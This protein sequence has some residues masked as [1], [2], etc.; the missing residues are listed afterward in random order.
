MLVMVGV[1]NAKN[2]TE[3]LGI[4][5]PAFERLGYESMFTADSESAVLPNVK[6]AIA[7]VLS[8][9]IGNGRSVDDIGNDYKNLQMYKGDYPT[10]KEWLALDVLT[11]K[12][13]Q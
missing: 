13:M 5:V 11:D 10:I 12:L 6:I 2:D 9:F 3:A 8:E 7:S 4:I 1:E